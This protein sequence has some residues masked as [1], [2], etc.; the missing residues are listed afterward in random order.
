MKVMTDVGTV[1]NGDAKSTLLTVKS[2]L[3]RTRFDS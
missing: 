3:V 1:E 2:S